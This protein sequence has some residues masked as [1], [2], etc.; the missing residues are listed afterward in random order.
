MTTITITNRELLAASIALRD[1]KVTNALASVKLG[2]MRKAVEAEATIVRD[3]IDE[4]A[5]RHATKTDAGAPLRKTAPGGAPLFLLST[6]T[7]AYEFA[8]DPAAALDAE[9]EPLFAA[10]VSLSVAPLTATDLAAIELA[11]NY[12]EL[13]LPFV[14]L[15]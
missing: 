8:P 10:P 15:E 9:L 11:G 1:A 14:A 3:A 12:G 7:P 5:Q 6:G 2:K 13:L 4:A